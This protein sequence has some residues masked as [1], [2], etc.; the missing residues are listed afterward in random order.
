MAG[1][2]DFVTGIR[3]IMGDKN[4]TFFQKIGTIF[5]EVVRFVLDGVMP[6][7]KVIF[8]EILKAMKEVPYV[9]ESLWKAGIK[10]E[11]SDDKTRKVTEAI[12]IDNKSGLTEIVKNF[13]KEDEDSSFFGDFFG[14]LGN[15]IMGVVDGVGGLAASTI[16][17]ESAAQELYQTSGA[18]FRRSG[19]DFGDAFTGGNEYKQALTT[20]ALKGGGYSDRKYL[21]LA[22]LDAIPEAMGAEMSQVQDA[23]ALSNG[24]I[25]SGSA[26]SAM[27]MISELNANRYASSNTSSSEQTITVVVNGEIEAKT[28]DGTQKINAKEFY[29]S[30]PVMMGEWIKR[31]MSQN[32]NGTA[33]YIVD[34]G[35]SPI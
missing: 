27:A 13:R 6:Y 8:G 26:G 14:G 9:G 30:D 15:G 34:F 20:E 35:V 31:T 25:L 2:K 1:F 17:W 33:N 29:D 22:G 28:K 7:V 21:E 23:L 12:G 16:G 4:K 5:G 11:M 19:A 3:E 18:R 10:M 24:K 32:G